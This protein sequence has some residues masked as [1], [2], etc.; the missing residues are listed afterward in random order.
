VAAV[1][2]TERL[3]LVTLPAEL[4]RLIEGGRIAELESTLGAQVPGGWTEGIPASLRLEQLSADPSEEPW[5]VRAMVLRAPRRVVGSVGFHAPPDWRGR[6]EI[7]YD[8]VATERRKGYAREGIHGLAAWAFVTGRAQICV[9]S[10]SP[11]NTPSLAL[12]R[13]LGFR[14]VGQQIDDVDGLE[15]VFERPLPLV[16]NR[17]HSLHGHDAPPHR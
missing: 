3:D 16:S 11:A 6:V 9:A 5:L 4:L 15:L 8:V 7:G 10:I 17:Y 14:L 12:A 13:S 2:A 1:I